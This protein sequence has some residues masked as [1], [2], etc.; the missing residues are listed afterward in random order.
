MVTLP[1]FL[2]LSEAA[3][4]YGLDEARL[5][6]LIEK[7]RIRAGILPG[8]DEVL[9]SEEEVRQRAEK[10]QSPGI[11][12]EE[13]PEYRQH[14]H[15]RG[16]AIWICEAARKYNLLAPTILKWIRL[17][18]INRIG[19]EG[20]KVLIDEADVAYCAEIYKKF[21]R[22]GRKTFDKNGLPYKPKT[23]TKRGIQHYEQ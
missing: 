11:R 7:G 9:V 22:Q 6:A 5:R 1:T 3:R 4:K 18:V 21:G 16:Q 2:P 12:K 20:N 10:E 17:G 13:L 19:V 8:T 23:K 14:A 15:L